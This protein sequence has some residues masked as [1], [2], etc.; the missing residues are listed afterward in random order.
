MTKYEIM[1]IVK[2]TLD[3]KTLADTTKEIQSLIT[4]NK[5]KVIE[6]KDLGRKK[7]AY[8]I[9]KELSGFYYLMNV[10]AT[11]VLVQEFDRKLRINE[12]IL[13]HLILKKESE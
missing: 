7:L 4:N 10:E 1:F 6:F 8:P 13:R 3:E 5:G 12:N 11:T 9:D 2:A